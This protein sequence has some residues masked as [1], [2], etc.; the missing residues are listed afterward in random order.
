[1]KNK[2]ANLNDANC[3]S[4]CFVEINNFLSDIYYKDT[5]KIT[6]VHLTNTKYDVVLTT[7]TAA[8]PWP[9]ESAGHPVADDRC[10]HGTLKCGN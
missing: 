6:H 2:C 4:I 1:M 9:L 10:N 8:V 3:T 7:N 5:S